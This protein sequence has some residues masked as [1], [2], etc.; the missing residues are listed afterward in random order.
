MSIVTRR[1]SWRGWRPRR[2]MGQPESQPSTVH[3]KG[4]DRRS[5]GPWPETREGDRARGPWSSG[6]AERHR[7]TSL[8]LRPG[9]R[10]QRIE[11]AKER[12][13]HGAGNSAERTSPPRRGRSRG[14][15][16]VCTW[17]R[18]EVQAGESVT[19]DSLGCCREGACRDDE[20]ARAWASEACPCRTCPTGP[21][22]PARGPAQRDR[23]P[24]AR[25]RAT[26]V[27]LGVSLASCQSRWDGTWS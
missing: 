14:R 20:K 3:E 17:R 5:R 2:E 1:S 12:G 25:L 6:S 15:A 16:P 22:P 4:E 9:E 13:A 19:G 24:R 11:D 8:G 18:S 23:L 7:E 26:L 10:G 21:G 27:E